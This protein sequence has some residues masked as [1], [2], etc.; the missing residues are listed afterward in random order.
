MEFARL[1]KLAR[2]PGL[3]VACVTTFGDC[4]IPDAHKGGGES[5][6]VDSPNLETP[7]Q[8]GNDLGICFE[9]WKPG[10]FWPV[11]QIRLSVGGGARDKM[12]KKGLLCTSRA[13]L[14]E[15]RPCGMAGQG[16]PAWASCVQEVHQSEGPAASVIRLTGGNGERLRQDE[17]AGPTSHCLAFASTG[18]GLV[19][20]DCASAESRLSIGCP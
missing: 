12:A 5:H 14:A 16:S 2:H 20:L 10:T 8:S 9:T 19:W 6:P 18:T 3:S 17:P 7:R 4:S 15:T 1:F 13:R 11:E